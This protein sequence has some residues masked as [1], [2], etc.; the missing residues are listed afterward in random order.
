MT[1]A[2]VPTSTTSATTYAAY[3]RPLF[4]RLPRALSTTGTFKLKKGDLQREGFDPA[5]VQDALFV[6]D[7]RVDR[8]VPL[9]AELFARLQAGELRL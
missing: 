3:A 1:S 2:P 8:Y 6:R 9:D 4:V 7:S 5:V